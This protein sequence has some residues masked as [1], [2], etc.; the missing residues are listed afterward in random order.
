AIVSLVAE[1]R[2]NG[3]Q[4]A[5]VPNTTNI[6]FE[7]T[8]GDALVL[9]LDEHGIEASRGSACTAGESDP[10]NVLMAMGLTGE[11]S[12]SSLRFSLGKLNTIS[13]IERVVSV[14]PAA[15]RRLREKSRF[16]WATAEGTNR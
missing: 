10:S 13:D 7:H 2:I 3:R 14:L 4:A 1:T 15:V 9:A 5:R 6:L 12:R 8:G 16:M 11:Q